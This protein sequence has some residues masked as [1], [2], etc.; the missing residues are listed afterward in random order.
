MTAKITSTG[1]ASSGNG[2]GGTN[3]SAEHTGLRGWFRKFAQQTSAAVGSPWAFIIAA[4]AVIVWA[5]TGPI[6][7]Y[8]DS[9]QLVINTSTTIVTFL[10]VFLIQ[11]T[12]NRD[13]RAMHLKLDELIR[14]IKAA[15]NQLVD[16]EELSDEELDRFQK[17]FA[18]L[19]ER[20]D[21]RRQA[22]REH[23][24]DQPE[25]SRYYRPG[26]EKPSNLA[27]FK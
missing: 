11:H 19:R 26:E 6:F 10:M 14:S 22:P 13:A 15:R 4:L 1:N 20:A 7:H 27:Q 9:W 23:D 24:Q 3:G 2:G 21:R 17:E 8:S 18:R 12:Q 25:A 5:V 16:L